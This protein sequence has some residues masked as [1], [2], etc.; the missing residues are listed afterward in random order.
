MSRWHLLL[1][2]EPRARAYPRRH[3]KWQCTLFL[4]ALA[5]AQQSEPNQ[6]ISL[7]FKLEELQAMPQWQSLHNGDQHPHHDLQTHIPRSHRLAGFP[8]SAVPS[9]TIC[10][11]ASKSC[12]QGPAHLHMPGA[13]IAA[14][15]L[16][17]ACTLQRRTTN[18]NIAPLDISDQVWKWPG[19]ERTADDLHPVLCIHAI[20][21]RGP[22]TETTDEIGSFV[23]KGLL[24]QSVF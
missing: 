8:E 7:T 22:H 6:S 18:I 17:A 3:L 1:L 2:P 11:L 24:Q 5:F 14:S 12:Q 23:Y 16:A 9:D 4:V 21:T 10:N 15:V 19:E 13:S 20:D